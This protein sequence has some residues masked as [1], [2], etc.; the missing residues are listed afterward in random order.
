LQTT[1][2]G[3]K[4]ELLVSES[5]IY[6]PL[7]SQHVHNKDYDFDTFIPDR[8]MKW[9]ILFLLMGT[10]LCWSVMDPNDGSVWSSNTEV[11]VKWN[12][13]SSDSMQTTAID[14]DLM[15]GPGDG[16]VVMEIGREIPG[17]ASQASWAVNEFLSTRSDYFI[18]LTQAG[19]NSSVLAYG[20]RFHIVSPS[21]MGIPPMYKDDKSAA[22]AS[23]LFGIDRTGS[24]VAALM[25]TVLLLCL[26]SH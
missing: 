5:W 23:V 16:V 3:R 22:S 19:S 11:T 26:F 17:S 15:V 25:V 8:E 9:N 21:M 1:L 13:T 4:A 12:S 24:K 6:C 2:I 10:A 20:E 14:V 7:T 18:R